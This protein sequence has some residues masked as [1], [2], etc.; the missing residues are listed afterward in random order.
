MSKTL[1]LSWTETVSREI[2]VTEVDGYV[3]CDAHGC[4]HEDRNDPYDEGSEDCN[5]SNWR[6]IWMEKDDE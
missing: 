5:K 6:T 2:A 1:T 4:G 3:W